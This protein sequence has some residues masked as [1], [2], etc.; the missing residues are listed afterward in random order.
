MN[1]QKKSEFSPCKQLTFQDIKLGDV[2]TINPAKLSF[3]L[4]VS[5]TQAFCLTHN[6]LTNITNSFYI[7]L[8][9]ATLVVDI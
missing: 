1:I 2:F 3:Y 6:Y 4:K 9:P 5:D 8:V 7:N